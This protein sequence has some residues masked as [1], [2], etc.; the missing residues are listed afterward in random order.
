MPSIPLFEQ[1]EPADLQRQFW[2]ATV[3][4]LL[5]FFGLAGRFWYLQ[6]FKASY[7]KKMSE[8]NRIRVFDIR[9]ARGIIFD[10]R[11]AI[12]QFPEFL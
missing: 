3:V 9:P 12:D 5:I 6:I 4:I 8:N 10:R 2:I 11:G 1:K 7:F